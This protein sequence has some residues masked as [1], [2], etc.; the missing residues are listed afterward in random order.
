MEKRGTNE[1]YPIKYEMKYVER[2]SILTFFTYLSLYIDQNE[3]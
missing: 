2:Q 3:A 1:H